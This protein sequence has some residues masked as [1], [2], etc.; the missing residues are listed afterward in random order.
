L[1]DCSM[2][3]GCPGPAMRQCQSTGSPLTTTCITD[4]SAASTA[5]RSKLPAA[6]TCS[7]VIF[8]LSGYVGMS[9]WTRQPRQL[10]RPFCEE[11]S[12]AGGV[13]ASDT[14]G[15]PAPAPF[16]AVTVTRSSFAPA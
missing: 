4:S 8:H 9:G 7:L 16:D 10:P 11:C 15:V 13:T 1:L 3:F 6:A 14:A 5:E 2:V 12:Y